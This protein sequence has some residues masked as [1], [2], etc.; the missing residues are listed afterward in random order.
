MTG[1][2]RGI[3]ASRLFLTTLVVFLVYAAAPSGVPA[4]SDVSTAK[5]AQSAKTQG[6]LIAQKYLTASRGGRLRARNG[7]ELRVPPRV[8]RRNGVARIR[9]LSRRR[10]DL[11]ISAPWK[12]RVTVMFPVGKGK[13]PAVSH[14]VRGRW[15][16][17]RARVVKGRAR[18]R[19]RSLSVFHT[20]E[21]RRYA[22][23]TMNLHYPEYVARAN[24]FRAQGCEYPPWDPKRG[25]CSKPL[26]Y[27]SFNW[28][29][30]GCSWTP[31]PA[32]IV[33][34]R[35]CQLHDFG[36]R[37]F[38]KGLTLERNEKKRKQIDIRFR[39][40]MYRICR[41]PRAFVPLGG[42]ARCRAI[43]LSMFGVVR[44]GSNWS[45]P[46]SGRPAPITHGPI[47]PL[48]PPNY[49]PQPPHQPVPPQPAPGPPPPPQVRGFTVEDVFLGGTWARADPNNGTWYSRGNRPANG[50]YWYP[51]GLGVGVDCARAAAGYV[52]KFAGGRTE[53]WN[54]WFH[55]TDGKWFPSAAARETRANGFY[56]LPGC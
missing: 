30:D 17:E 40:E 53:T 33:F 54:T 14:R 32:R 38:G 8:M 1:L 21:Q 36:Y 20:D 25:K 44:N 45:A 56:G 41:D 11:H 18:L 28:T 24:D 50:A 23:E 13:V 26:P 39:D 43:A 10:F 47:A 31:P 22:E 37:N 7:V 15:V 46:E 49:Q 52:V 5:A 19:V 16:V 3:R 2:T 27:D 6:R 48:P 4:P 9:R 42:L 12:G 51:N 55:V 35:P 34:N 29:T